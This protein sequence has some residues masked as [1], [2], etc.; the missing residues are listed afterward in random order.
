MFDSKSSEER[1][2]FLCTLTLT[3]DFVQTWGKHS[4]LATQEAHFAFKTG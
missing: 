1:V 3:Q 4:F 2:A